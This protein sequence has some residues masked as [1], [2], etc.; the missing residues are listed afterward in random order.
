MRTVL[1]S[2]QIPVFH[3]T[4][5]DDY[6]DE[7]RS[8]QAERRPSGAGWDVS[9]GV[10]HKTSIQKASGVRRKAQVIWQM[11]PWS[12]EQGAWSREQGARSK[13]QGARPI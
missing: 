2:C 8:R 7:L 10:F 11:G 9:E 5:W 3:F 12:M 1:E 4:I 13:E 6:D